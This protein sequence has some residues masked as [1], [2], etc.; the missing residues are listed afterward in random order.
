MVKPLSD[1]IM[2]S[3]HQFQRAARYWY[4][5]R[6]LDVLSPDDETNFKTFPLRSAGQPL[7]DFLG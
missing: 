5:G 7:S 4:R 1:R 3:R 2:V 6:G